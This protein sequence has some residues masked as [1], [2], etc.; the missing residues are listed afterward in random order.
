MKIKARPAEK[1]YRSTKAKWILFENG[2]EQTVEVTVQYY[3]PSV[4]EIREAR[5]R[6]A[7]KVN[8]DPEAIVWLSDLLAERI[9]AI[10]ELVDDDEKPVEISAEL[11]E[12]QDLRNLQSL[13]EAIKADQDPKSKPP[14]GT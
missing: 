1:P 14:I 9:H 5:E 2:E 3:S 13:D 6:L 4:R 7:A 11:L 8:G 10:P 12:L